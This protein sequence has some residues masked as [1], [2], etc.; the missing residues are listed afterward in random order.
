MLTENDYLKKT[1]NVVV[2]KWPPSAF[3][4]AGTFASG[5]V[6]PAGFDWLDDRFDIK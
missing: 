1:E 3:D 5:V 4:T 2:M 6:H